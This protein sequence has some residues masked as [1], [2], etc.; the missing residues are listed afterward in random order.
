MRLRPR[1]HLLLLVLGAGLAPLAWTESCASQ[2]PDSLTA[3]PGGPEIEAPQEE[4]V[5]SGISPRGAF[6]RSAILP[7]WGH[8]RVGAQVRGAFYF[9]AEATSALMIY[10]TNTRIDRTRRKLALRESVVTA[11]FE[12]AGATEEEIEAALE[13]DAEIEDLRSLEET[14]TGQREDWIALG[15]FLMLI[16]GV[17]GY[18]SAH[19]ADFPTAVVIEPNTNGGMEIG[20][21]LPVG[22]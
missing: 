10:K 14:R 15:L 19:L 7:G 13:E 20:L 3:P 12:A 6:I 18:V 22:F 11:R 5:P 8:A 1:L 2:E 4:V 21:S 16:G 9:A 17:D